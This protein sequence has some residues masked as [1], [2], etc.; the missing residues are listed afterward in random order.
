MPYRWDVSTDAEITVYW[1]Y[2]TAQGNGTCCWAI[3]YKAIK[4]GEAVT[5]AG[6][7]IAKTSAGTHTTGQLVRTVFTTK[8]LG[9]NLENHDSLGFR[10]YRDVDGGG[11]AGD[12]L[13]TN[14]RLVNTHFHFTMNK[15]GAAL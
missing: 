13:A 15:L 1:Y 7:T 12:T 14:A 2:A 9:A 6:T 10:L 4:A 11:D 5:G 3:E 8:I